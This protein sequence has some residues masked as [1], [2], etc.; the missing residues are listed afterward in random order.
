MK[1]AG[2]RKMEV[3]MKEGYMR[4]GPR[5]FGGHLH[6]R[7]SFLIRSSKGINPRLLLAPGVATSFLTLNSFC[8]DYSPY[9]L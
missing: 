8:P 3:E 5:Q 4:K 6:L 9:V 1:E 2:S 7:V